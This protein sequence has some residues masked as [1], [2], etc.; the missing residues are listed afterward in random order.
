M[1]Q[2]QEQIET[3]IIDK[4]VE[5]TN[6]EK[7]IE[8]S[9]KIWAWVFLIFAVA[10]AISPIDLVPDVSAVGLIDDVIVVLAALINFVQQHFLQTHP[11][12][13]KW[14]RITKLILIF[15][16]LLITLVALL[17]GVYILYLLMS[18]S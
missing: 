5:E 4:T 15:F 9:K 3:K 13:N 10:Y 7:K 2:N 1:L 6:K 12:L 16:A 8:E 17:V 18:P 11:T 14:F